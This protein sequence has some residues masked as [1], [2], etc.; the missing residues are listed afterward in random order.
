MCNTRE[1]RQNALMPRPRS[2]ERDRRVLTQTASVEPDS[3]RN[4]CRVRHHGWGQSCLGG[5][6]NTAPHSDELVAIQHALEHALHR[7]GGKLFPGNTT[8]IM[9]GAWQGRDVVPGSNWNP[10]HVGRSEVTRGRRDAA[11]SEPPAAPASTMQV[12]PSLYSSS[13]R[14]R[15]GAASTLA[16]PPDTPR[17]GGQGRGRRLVRCS[18]RLPPT[19]RHPAKQTPGQMAHTAACA[20]L[21]LLTREESTGGR[22]WPSVRPLRGCTPVAHWAG[23]NSVLAPPPPPLRPGPAPAAQAGRWGALRCVQGRAAS[24]SATPESR[25]VGG[26]CEQRPL[27]ADHITYPHP[28]APGRGQYAVTHRTTLQPGPLQLA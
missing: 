13:R 5:R 21:G 7:R 23:T 12:P 27:P 19:G 26:C 14:M 11:Q 25:D 18:Q 9:D 16:A 28:V 3:G 2:P 17:A 8:P 6:S 4:R 24:W 15:D 1:L 22:R 20:V 10:S